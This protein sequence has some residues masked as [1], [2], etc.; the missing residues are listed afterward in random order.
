MKK[1]DGNI[2]EAEKKASAKP[3]KHF[4]KCNIGGGGKRHK[5]WGLRALEPFS[6][7]LKHQVY[8]FNSFSSI[9]IINGF[10]SRGLLFSFQAFKRLLKSA[11]W[12]FY[13]LMKIKA[14]FYI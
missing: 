1:Q 14:L 3:S 8:L 10:S 13:A 7:S 5:L 4:N 12:G 11:L 9:Q 6:S 2:F